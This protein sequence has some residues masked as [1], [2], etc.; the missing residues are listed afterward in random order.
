MS[1]NKNALLRY[2]TL[3]RCFRNPGRLFFWEDLL[4][5][6]NEA[7]LAHHPDSNGIQRRQL[8]D[9]I[10]FMESEQ[11]WSA[12]IARHKQGRKTYYR[13]SDLRFSIN[14][15]TLNA[16]EIEQLRTALTV[17]GRFA[18]T[19]LFE[20]VNE[21]VPRI[22]AKFGLI[23]QP[24]EVIHFEQ[25]VDL[26]GL[27][28]LPPLFNAI[29]HRRV[30]RITYRDF[31]FP[32]PYALPFHPYHL[33]QYNTRWFCFGLNADRDVPTW[34]LALDRIEAVEEIADAYI[35]SDTDWTDYFYDIVGVSRPP[36]AEPQEILLQFNAAVAP[37][38]RTKP[39]HPSQRATVNERG[40]AVRLRLIPNFELEKLLL[41]FGEAVEVVEPVGLRARVGER[42][43]EAIK[44]YKKRN[45][46]I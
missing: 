16:T 42:L 43:G 34:N 25:N 12:P 20:W 40:L 30:L 3:D 39:L 9:D 44:T 14:D 28:H 8:F 4:K 13:Y 17:I 46:N 31:K 37:Y 26:K 2:Q 27:E 22:E 5:A 45:D 21:L 19:P 23:D 18:G 29:V 7:L 38:V 35:A 33:R 15:E 6:C 24:A 1:V 10:R 32:E 11:G 41:S 36:E